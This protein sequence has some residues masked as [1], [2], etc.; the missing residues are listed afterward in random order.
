MSRVHDALRRAETGG[1]LPDHQ[2]L[3]VRPE[4]PLEFLPVT[5]N[6]APL[7][8]LNLHILQHAGVQVQPHQGGRI[9]SHGKELQGDLGANRKRLVVR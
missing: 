2:P 9:G 8:R 3:P 4:V 6:T 7:V 5:A 1:D